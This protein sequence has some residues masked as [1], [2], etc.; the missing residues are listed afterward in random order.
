MKKSNNKGF[1]L[2]EAVLA[3]AV[4]VI[5]VAS[6]V[7][8]SRMSIKSSAISLDRVQAYYLAQEGIEAVR[9]IRDT[10]WLSSAGNPWLND[11]CVD[12]YCLA[13]PEYTSG[14]YWQ[15]STDLEKYKNVVLS[16]KTFTRTISILSP[17]SGVDTSLKGFGIQN[18][19]NNK[20]KKVEVKVTW[21]AYNQDWS[22]VVVTY[23]SDWKPT[24]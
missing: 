9:Q 8:L 5:V 11:V 16:N 23:L 7:T 12:C 1:G 13:G 3:I 24:F 4:L 20:L 10:N 18:T 6:T 2:L 14:N 17:E 22:T 15:L 19:N 21:K